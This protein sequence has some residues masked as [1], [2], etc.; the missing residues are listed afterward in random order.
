M[1]GA[2]LASGVEAGEEEEKEEEEEDGG[3]E[4]GGMRTKGNSLLCV[5]ICIWLSWL[6][7]QWTLARSTM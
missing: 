2:V 6:V 4:A 5:C 1:P 3:G 7:T